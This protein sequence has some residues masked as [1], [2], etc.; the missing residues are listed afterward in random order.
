M[1]WGSLSPQPPDIELVRVRQR[2]HRQFYTS[3]AADVSSGTGGGQGHHNEA[4]DLR[5]LPGLVGFADSPH[6]LEYT[7]VDNL[8]WQ[9][10]LCVTM[11]F[12]FSVLVFNPNESKPLL[13]IS[14]FAWSLTWLLPARRPSST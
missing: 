2:Q 14:R 3:W 13:I 7:L 8:I 5:P 11:Y 1:V 4:L 12:V 6:F 10:T 9:A